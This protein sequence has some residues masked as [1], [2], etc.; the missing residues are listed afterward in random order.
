LE[1]GVT[2]EVAF[3]LKPVTEADL[4]HMARIE[5]AAK[6]KAKEEEQLM[7]EAEMNRAEEEDSRYFQG[8]LF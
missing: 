3:S 2:D 7:R 6:Q 4:D 8:E 1:L 5:E